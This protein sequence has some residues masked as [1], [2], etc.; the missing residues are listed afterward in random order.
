MAAPTC[1]VNAQR[2]YQ[3]FD[4][5]LKEWRTDLKVLD[6]VSSPDGALTPLASFSVEPD[7]AGL[8]G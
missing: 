5:T 6:R 8:A 4:V 1:V 7:R 3:T 2:G